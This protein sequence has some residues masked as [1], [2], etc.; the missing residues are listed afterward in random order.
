MAR[1]RE[2]VAAILTS[3]LLMTP[4]WGA[5]I[6]AIGTVVASEGASVGAAGAPVGTTVFAGDKLSTADAGSVQLRT[7]AARF[8]LGASSAATVNEDGGMPGATLL[9]GS[10]TFSTANAKAF[11]L[12][13]STAVIRPKSDGPTIGQVTMLGKKQLLVKCT[14]GALTITVGNDS[15]VIA[16]GD[17]YRVVLDP[18]PSEEAQNQP[19]PQGAG[20]KGSGG[21]PISA[22]TSKFV[23]YA[24]AAVAA[25]TIIA[26]HEALE[27]PDRP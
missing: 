3:C 23:W 8:L 15:R 11:A 19:P 16:E 14:R 17:A 12:N 24:T 2:I 22:G 13:A 27:S 5:S 1:S 21:P 20:T 4:V 6:A 18:S 9:R 26:V 25:V 10:A 7:S